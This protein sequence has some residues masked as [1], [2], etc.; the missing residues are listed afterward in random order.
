M[1]PA[2]GAGVLVTLQSSSRLIEFQIILI[3]YII[4]N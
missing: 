1:S 3:I 2:A 4:M